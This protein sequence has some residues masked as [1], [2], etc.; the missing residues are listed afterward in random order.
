MDVSRQRCT[1]IPCRIVGKSVTVETDVVKSGMPLKNNIEKANTKINIANDKVNLFDKEV[2][3]WF[4]S[5]GHYAIPLRDSCKALDSDLEESQLTEVLLTINI[6]RKFNK[7]KH[8]IAIKLHRQ[9]GHPKSSCLIDLVKSAGISDNEFLDF[10]KNIDESCEICIY[11]KETKIKTFCWLLLST[12]FQWNSGSGFETFQKR[13]YL[14][15]CRSF[16]KIYWGSNDLL[17]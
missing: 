11:Y 17:K 6:A 4:A 8:Q 2:N 7:E 12:W 5:S 14:A 10:L 16:S 13:V 15:S 9:F 3:I 1:L